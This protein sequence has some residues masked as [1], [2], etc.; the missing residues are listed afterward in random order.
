MFARVTFYPTLLYNVFMEKVTQRNWYDRI[1][2]T[3]ILGAL[4][5]R[6]ISQK[7]IEEE[8]V[9][10]IISMNEG[11]EL[12]HFTPHPDEWKKMGVEHCQ[13]STRDIFETPSHEKL[14]QGVSTIESFSKNGKSVYVHCKA[15]RTRSATL[16]GCY[17][18]AKHNW[19]P[20]Q[21]IENIV[22]KRPHIWLRNQQ[23]ESLKQYYNAVV[24]EKF[25]NAAQY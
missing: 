4:P 3:V 21:A 18:M 8:N 11:Y 10:C 23:L 13:L 25:S 17:L 14:V 2:E 19:T 24:K 5:F 12:E 16:V 7:L 22:S 9:R 20:E 15:G 1:D 6:T